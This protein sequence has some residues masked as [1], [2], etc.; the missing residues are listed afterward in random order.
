[1]E[2]I[3]SIVIDKP[4]PLPIVFPR[5]KSVIETKTCVGLKRSI[6]S[7]VTLVFVCVDVRPYG[8]VT[9][10]W[11][12][13]CN[14]PCPAP[15]LPGE[16][17]M[18]GNGSCWENGSSKLASFSQCDQMKGCS[19]ESTKLR[20]RFVQDCICKGQVKEVFGTCFQE[21]INAKPETR[22]RNP[23]AETLNPKP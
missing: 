13:C 17:V 14:S 3:N 20:V 2:L 7:S 10:P 1:M 18:C 12:G 21:S 4:I 5:W 22:N 8:C 23:K 9:S 6:P 11:W 15:A 16:H 19:Q